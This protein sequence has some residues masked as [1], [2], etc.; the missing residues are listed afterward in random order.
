MCI[1]SF[2]IQDSSEEFLDCD[3]LGCRKAGEDQNQTWDISKAPVDAVGVSSA[4]RSSF[5]VLQSILR[6]REGSL[7]GQRHCT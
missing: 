1:S 3:E 2:E 6:V 4:C 7:S 5:I